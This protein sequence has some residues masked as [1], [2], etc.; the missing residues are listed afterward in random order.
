MNLNYPNN[1]TL[2]ADTSNYKL[3]AWILWYLFTPHSTYLAVNTS[4]TFANT[5][6]FSL[7]V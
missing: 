4:S 6:Q 2:P 3:Q 5:T 1:L 7:T